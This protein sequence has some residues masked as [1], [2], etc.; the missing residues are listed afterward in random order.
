MPNE[1]TPPEGQDLAQ[2]L[3]AV[4]SL[5][6]DL[7]SINERI[8]GIEEASK[9]VE[10]P[11]DPALD[12]RNA[13]PADWRTL[14][15]EIEQTADAKAEAK[16]IAKEEEKISKQEEMKVAEKEWDNKFEQEAAQAVK[17]GYLPEVV[18]PKDHN[19]PG[20]A[21][22]RD[23]FGFAHFMGT[24]DLLKI[25]ETV[26]MYNQSG[27]HF[28]VDQSKWIQSEYRVPGKFAPIG[29]SSNRTSTPGQGISYKELHNSSLDRLLQKA[30]QK[31]DL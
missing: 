24:T 31:Y 6:A 2:L 20:N 4:N 18:N 5:G 10:I 28:D 30:K 8:S 9:P 13:P 11:L 21:A 14:R 17:D 22:R 19:D 1:E 27:K 15:D 7:Q 16:L 3:E 29:S 25:A 26:K 12:P 23:L